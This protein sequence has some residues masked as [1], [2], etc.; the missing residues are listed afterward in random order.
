MNDEQKWREPTDEERRMLYEHLTEKDRHPDEQV[1]EALETAY[2]VVLE[3]F[4]S[5]KLEYSQRILIV[6]YSAP[7]TLEAYEFHDDVPE[8]DDDGGLYRF[9]TPSH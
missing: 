6:I 5:G 3:N 9:V 1:S 8:Y 2:M 4:E 7:A